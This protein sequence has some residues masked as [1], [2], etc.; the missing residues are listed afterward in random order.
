MNVYFF[1]LYLYIGSLFLVRPGHADMSQR[2]DCWVSEQEGPPSV[3]LQRRVLVLWPH[4]QETE[5]E[6]QGLQVS[7]TGQ[8]SL[9]HTRVPFSHTLQ[10]QRRRE[11]KQRVNL[12][13]SK[14]TKQ[15]QSMQSHS[16]QVLQSTESSSLGRNSSVPLPDGIPHRHSASETQRP[17]CSNWPSGQRHPEKERNR[18]RE[19]EKHTLFLSSFEAF[20]MI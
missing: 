2:S 18:M 13:D 9:V 8:E 3:S 10:S 4:P 6:L 16:Y 17:S 1:P 15:R 20:Y 11:K 5:Q 7:Y 19:T 12:I 14:S